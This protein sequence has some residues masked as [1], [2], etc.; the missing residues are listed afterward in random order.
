M[1]SGAMG[2]LMKRE[3]SWSQWVH[4]LERK[5]IILVAATT[6]DSLTECCF[7]LR[8]LNLIIYPSPH[9]E[10]PVVSGAPSML[11][12]FNTIQFLEFPETTKAV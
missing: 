8:M 4:F 3:K 2:A 1:I 11:C 5:T 10:A 9:P 12:I 6:I 7:N